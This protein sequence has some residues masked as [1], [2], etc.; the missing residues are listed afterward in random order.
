MYAALIL[1]PFFSIII[2]NLPFKNLMKGI[3][4]WVGLLLSFAEV[5]YAIFPSAFSQY[6]S[7]R[8]LNNLFS[9]NLAVD[10]LTRVMLLCIGIV[11][12]ITLLMAKY[13]MK[14]EGQNFNFTNLLLVLLAGLNGVVLVKDVFSLYVF[15]EV[16]AVASFILIAFYKDSFALEGAFKYIILSAVASV[17]MLSAIS[18]LV[19]VSG[20]TDFSIINF[21]LQNYPHNLV[22]KVALGLFI[23]GLF[24]KSGLMPFHG[25]LPDAYSSAS[26][27]VSVLL[28]GIVTKTAGVYGLIRIINSVFGFDNQLKIILMSIGAISI[29]LGALAALGQSDFKRMLAYS[30]ISQVG[31][32]IL[33]LGS[34]AALGIA[35]AI[36]HL[37]NHA[38]FKSL[39]FTN[40]AAVE[41]QTGIRDMDKMEGL[42]TRMPLTSLS[43]VIGSLSA[44]GI[45]PLAGFWSKLI[46]IIALW[47]SGY[48]IFAVIAVVGS[49]LTLAYFLSMQRRL[50]FGKTTEDFANIKEVGIG[51]LIPVF[52]LTIITLAVGLFFPLLLNTFMLPVKS[53]LGG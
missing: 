36:F 25:W 20:S 52:I 40:S 21:A 50:F 33:G 18:L 41:S 8:Q 27:P 5:M 43:S 16:V 17:L 53:I 1:I 19:L 30:S 22:I 6:S 2:L 51:L 37:F 49:V 32:I 44:A 10:N 9:F 12:F 31:Y 39:L 42:A 34:G 3:A 26:A 7:L 46:I 35:G 4:L 14:E 23:C 29:I 48:K 45:P 13:L 15:I 38:I 24:I 28:A 47:I 11:L